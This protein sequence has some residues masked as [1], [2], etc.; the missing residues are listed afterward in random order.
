VTSQLS[1]DAGTS[2]TASYG[3]LVGLGALFRKDVREWLRGRRAWVL[4]VVT[5]AFMALSA[6]NGWI[7]AQIVAALPPG[8]ETPGI[9]VPEYSLSPL[10]NLLTAIGTQIFVLATILAVVSLI[11][12]E[13]QT[14]TL[15]WT[16]SKPVSRAAIW[17]SK[18]LS[19][20][21]MLAITAAIV[22]FAATLGVVVALYGAPPIEL[23]V[24]G[25][26]GAVALIMFFAALGLAAGTVMPGQAAIA[27]VG[28]GYFAVVPT[29]VGLVPLPLAP[30]LPT[31]ILT[32]ALG[33]AVGQDVGLI[34]PI[35]WAVWTAGL[36]WFAI[37]R[38]NRMEL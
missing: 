19:S 33:L 11:V 38:M 24:A 9:E 17:L 29:L 34:S 13:R 37:N 36:A 21:V 8:A 27:A 3:P 16:A 14:G 5:T 18:W 30:F 31:S 35:A 23:F 26:L 20:S 2:R 32:W 7:S 1:Y 28:F 6:A 25:L 15:A 22:P 4:L 12:A 10:D